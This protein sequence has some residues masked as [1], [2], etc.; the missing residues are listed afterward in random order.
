MGKCA[1]GKSTQKNSALCA[2][3]A[4]L[5]KIGLH[6]GASEDEIRSAYLDQVKAWHP[7]RYVEG[8][9]KQHTA[10]ENLKRVNIAYKLLTSPSDRG[11]DP[12]RPH[13]S[14]SSGPKRPQSSSTTADSTN[15]Q[16]A[17]SPKFQHGASGKQEQPPKASATG[18]F[19]PG[20]F[21]QRLSHYPQ[22]D[23]K[24][25]EAKF[26][27][28]LINGSDAAKGLK[29]WIG[30]EEA[31][32][33]SNIALIEGNCKRLG[34]TPNLKGLAK[35]EDARADVI[36]SLWI[37]SAPNVQ[38][39]T[40]AAK[41]DKL[42]L[43]HMEKLKDSVDTF[44]KGIEKRSAKLMTQDMIFRIPLNDVLKHCIE[45]S[46]SIHTTSQLAKRKH[47]YPLDIA[48]C[49]TG[50]VLDLEDRRGLSQKQS[51]ALIRCALLAHGCTEEEVSPFNEELVERG[52][53]RAK[54]EALR[55][56]IFESA[57]VIAAH[58]RKS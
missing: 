6:A 39:R 57:D 31:Q 20:P 40:S 54:R 29:K 28:V 49:C 9:S 44:A 14:G 18:R 55:K 22:P 41:T 43:K 35:P 56:S 3:C 7:D 5:H 27:E 48:D 16:K 46:S 13:S 36:R 10:A 21:K 34:V 32:R 52:T 1:C 26:N 51:H 17:R 58:V 2:R 37:H 19:P 38:Q 15:S 42:F 25:W 45:L 53:I 23:F 8:T 24:K 11:G 12:D 33:A 50:L 47:I 30:H 4:A